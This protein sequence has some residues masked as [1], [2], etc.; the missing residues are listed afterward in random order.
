MA[1]ER[2]FFEIPRR[3]TLDELGEE[4]GISNQSVSERLHWSYGCL[5]ENF[6]L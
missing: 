5:V 2:G 3:V 1:Y 4:L 6:V